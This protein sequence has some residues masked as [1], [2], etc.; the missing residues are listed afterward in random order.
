MR[1]SDRGQSHTP[2]PREDKPEGPTYSG[3]LTY[4]LAPDELE[5]KRAEWDRMLEAEKRGKEQF[6][7]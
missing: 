7:Q 1:L 3:V 6:G 5:A 2:I 4:I